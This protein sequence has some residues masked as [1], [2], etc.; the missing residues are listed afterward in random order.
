[1]NDHRDALARR[2]FDRFL[3]GQIG[4]SHFDRALDAAL[5]WTGGP[6]STD[7]VNAVVAASGSSRIIR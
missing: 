6:P 1:M 3:V 7:D 2:V 5:A 4:R